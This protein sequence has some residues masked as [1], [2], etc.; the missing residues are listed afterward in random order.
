M[1]I[2]GVVLGFMLALLAFVAGCGESSEASDTGSD[3]GVATQLQFTAKTVDG[4]AF[5]G[6]QL[7]GTPTVVWFWKPEC[8]HCKKEAGTIA[9]M[10]EAYDNANFVGIA[11]QSNADAM[12]AFVEEYGTGGFPNL[13]D[14]DG[15]V[16]LKF[17]VTQQPAYALV[18]ADGEVTTEQGNLTEDAVASW[19][20]SQQA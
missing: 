2:H 17:G 9:A 7:A 19:L 16:S 20:E 6:T 10:A 15:D 14:V 11:G 12:R 18:G 1:R 5:D 3:T 13:V 4:E 8:A